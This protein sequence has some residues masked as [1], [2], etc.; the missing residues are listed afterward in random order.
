MKNI[1]VMHVLM[2]MTYKGYPI[3]VRKIYNDMYLWD[4]WCD[5]HYSSY[6]IMK[7]AKGKRKLTDLE[8]DEVIKMCYAGAAATIDTKLGIELSETDQA[9]VNLFESARKEEKEN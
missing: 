4:T 3:T 9:V 2:Q 1:A 7:P 6:I 5:G 8:R